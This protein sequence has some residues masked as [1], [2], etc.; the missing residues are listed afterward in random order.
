MSFK[1]IL[2]TQHDRNTHAELT[3][4]DESGLPDGDVDVDV[5][6]S[7]LNYKDGLA[8]TGKG[9]VVRTWPMVAGI[10]VPTAWTTGAGDMTNGV[11]AVV[12]GIVKAVATVVG[13]ASARCAIPVDA[14]PETP[15]EMIVRFVNPA[16]TP[17]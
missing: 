3:D 14:S 8:I 6:W 16:S 5:A 17:G 4:I 12:V 9:A 1:G 2:L 7:T 15:R 13:I 10:D 11:D